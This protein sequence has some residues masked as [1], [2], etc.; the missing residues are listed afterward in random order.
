[1]ALKKIIREFNDESDRLAPDV[2]KFFENSSHDLTA[3]NIQRYFKVGYRRGIRIY[4]QIQ[5]L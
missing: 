4:N 5:K 2:K 3:A 1:M